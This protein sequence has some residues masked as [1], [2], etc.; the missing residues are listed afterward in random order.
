MRRIYRESEIFAQC[1]KTIYFVAGTK[2]DAAMQRQIAIC[3]DNLHS[4]GIYDYRIKILDTA[5]S[6]I[7]SPEALTLRCHPADRPATALQP[8][9]TVAA[10]IDIDTSHTGT[11]I[12]EIIIEDDIKPDTAEEQTARI[13]NCIIACEGDSA[14][15]TLREE[16]RN[17]IM[18]RMSGQFDV[19][20]E[21]KAENERII[22][23]DILAE[24]ITPNNDISP[25]TL[26]ID[27]RFDIHLPQYPDIR[28]ELA[29]LPKAL[30]ILLLLHPEGL[31]LKEIA[32]YKEELGN[33]Y[34]IVSGRQNP[35]VIKRAVEN[36]I[37]PSD[38]P[39]HK[40]LSIIRHAFL[41]KLRSD[42][43]EHYIP[44]H[45]R[46]SNHRIPLHNNMIELPLN[47]L[48]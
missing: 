19:A 41:C 44:S 7:L 34:R 47:L 14:R 48:R 16:R 40:N 24:S 35:S 4:H 26:Y 15:C 28:I 3:L 45:G 27:E 43:A 12:A 22:E 32:K 8:K 30:Y 37:N 13:T 10:I 38:N 33:I 17:R 21:E 2:C 25:S 31:M 29:A 18:F 46:R 9:R 1:E 5:E 11:P 23:A 36:I 6:G 39:L 20:T 42:I